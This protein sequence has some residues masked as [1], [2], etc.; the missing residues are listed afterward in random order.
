M[1]GHCN[2]RYRFP[3]SAPDD[4]FGEKNT[5]FARKRA[6]EQFEGFAVDTE[7][8]NTYIQK[9][10]LRMEDIY[11]CSGIA[12]GSSKDFWDTQKLLVDMALD[13]HGTGARFYSFKEIYSL[14]LEA[15]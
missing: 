10:A 3:Y 14:K 4:G 8:W 5:T 13:S 15:G 1:I 6:K 2:A 7:S 11:L 12:S 9:A